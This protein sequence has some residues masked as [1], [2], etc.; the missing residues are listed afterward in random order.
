MITYHRLLELLDYDPATGMF[1][2]RVKRH[3]VKAGTVAG[4]LHGTGYVVISADGQI[5]L[6]HRLAWL[7]MTGKWPSD[8]IDH[9]NLDRSDNRW[10]NLREATR[11]QNRANAPIHAHNKVRLK[12]V[13]RAPAKLDKPF[14]AEIRKDGKRYF[15]GYF[16]T[17]EEAHAAYGAAATSLHGE[18]ARA[19]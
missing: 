17:K 1:R 11:S 14:R 9:A 3:R 4:C 2:W 15:L 10:S 6:A 18:F 12:G 16:K 5:Y 8:D 19:S 7:W 13:Y